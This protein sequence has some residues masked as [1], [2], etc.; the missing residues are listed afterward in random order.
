MDETEHPRLLAICTAAPWPVR[1]GYTLRVFSLL[2]ELSLRWS[3]TLIAPPSPPDIPLDLARQIPVAL[4]GTGLSYPWRF[5]QTALR[6]ALTQAMRTGEYDCALVWPGAESLWFGGAGLPP[7]VADMI[8]CNSLEFWRDTWSGRS[9]RSRLRSLRQLGVATQC[10][11]LTVRRFSATACV[12]EDDAAWLR[13]MGPASNVHVVPNGVDLPELKTPE[14]DSPTLSFVGTLDFQPNIDAVLYAARAI[15]PLVKEALPTA[16]FV[17]AGRRPTADI[18]GLHGQNGISIAADVEDMTAVLRRSWIST[19]PMRSGVGIKNK[20]LEAW[21]CARPV[22]LTP[23][24][25]NGLVLPEGHTSLVQ[26]SAAGM[27]AAI[28]LLLRDDARRHVLGQSAR[29]HVEQHCSWRHAAAAI[30]ALLSAAARQN[31]SGA[32]ARATL[33]P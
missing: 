32:R 4:Q 14:A 6:A 10:G 9:L 17:I 19:A 27:A 1:D 11:M 20:V 16:S 26:Q 30:D 24:A 31:A 33:S 18:R 25:T 5:D 21:A 29:A 7:A 8:D 13:W 28:L 12:G 23:M 15:W 2:R 3:I 22:V